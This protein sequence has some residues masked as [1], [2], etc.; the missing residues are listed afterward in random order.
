M[1]SVILMPF[2]F[3]CMKKNARKMIIVDD[4]FFPFSQGAISTTREQTMT[5]YGKYRNQE[6]LQPKLLKLHQNW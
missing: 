1:L 2:K 3:Y 4:K 5:F 6:V